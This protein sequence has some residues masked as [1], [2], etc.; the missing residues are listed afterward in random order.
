MA[1][2]KTIESS[3]LVEVKNPNA[4]LFEDAKE[5]KILFSL[6]G[7]DQY[8]HI[9]DFKKYSDIGIEPLAEIGI[10]QDGKILFVEVNKATKEIARVTINRIARMSGIET[11][12]GKK[13]ETLRE[14]ASNIFEKINSKKYDGLFEDIENFFSSGTPVALVLQPFTTGSDFYIAT[15]DELNPHG[16][17]VKF[18]NAN[19][20]G[21]PI[22][23]LYN[24]K[25]GIKTF[26][27]KVEIFYKNKL[28]E[29][30]KPQE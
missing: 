30:G 1:S 23:K 14:E 25:Q 27:K 11:K 13:S 7:V 18:E 6:N 17:V 9:D 15:K 3:S 20:K 2:K 8:L 10:A 12:E 19:A 29:E 24:E 4:K 22:E 21:V 26:E 28:A 16:E 5:I